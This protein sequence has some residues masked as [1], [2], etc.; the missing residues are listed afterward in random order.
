MKLS[1]IS[2]GVSFIRIK[3]GICLI[4]FFF[5]VGCNPEKVSYEPQMGT[6]PLPDNVDQLL[7]T[8]SVLT[9]LEGF[10]SD[11]QRVDSL[12]SYTDVLQNYKENIALLYAEKADSLAEVNNW[13]EA[14][15]FSKQ[16]IGMLKG[17][18]QSFGEKIEY[19]IVDAQIGLQLFEE[20]GNQPWRARTM[21][22][23]GSFFIRKKQTD[24]AD[25][26]FHRALD[27]VENANMS[28]QDS[29]FLRGEIFHAITNLYFATDTSKVL[30]SA[31]ETLELYEKADNQAAIARLKLSMG[32]HFIQL[33]EFGKANQLIQESIDYSISSRDFHSL[34]LG[35]R[36]RGLLK[37][38]QFKVERKGELLL[39]ALD[40][41]RKCEEYE[42]ENLYVTDNLI[43]YCF[44]GL[45][46]THPP[47]TEVYIDSALIYYKRAM[48]EARGE[49]VLPVMKI[50]G[51]NIAALCSYL[52]TYKN[53]DCGKI[54]GQSPAKLFNDNYIGIVDTITQTLQ[55]ADRR[56][57]NF[58]REEAKKEASQKRR[59]QL[60]IGTFLLLVCCLAF[61][62]W[63]D[64]EQQQKLR[65]EQSINERLQQ[66]DKLKD[67]FLANTSHE[68]RT[69][70][71]GIIGLS[72]SLIDRV[73]DVEQ[74]EDLSL[75]VA[76]G[77]RLSSLVDDLLDF[78]KLKNFDIEL[79]KKP[80]DLYSLAEVV[81][82]TSASLSGKDVELINSI[83]KDL[84]AVYADEGR[85]QQILY[86]LIGNALKF[87]QEGK[88]EIEASPDK[89]NPDKMMKIRI[90]DTGIG[91]PKEKHATIFEEFQQADGSTSRKFGGTGLGLTVTRQLVNLHKG[92]IGVESEVGKGATFWFTLPTSRETG[93]VM[94][95]L[96]GKTG[97][98]RLQS[99]REPTVLNP[100]PA[101]NNGNQIRILI[102]D[103][104]PINQQVLKNHLSDSRFDLG[105]AA[106]GEETLEI[107]EKSPDFDLVLLDVMMPKMS[108]Y[109][110]CEK[111]REKYL[112]SEL[113]IIMVTAKNQVEDLVQGLQLGANDYLAKPFSKQEFLARVNTQLDL[114]RFFN[115]AEKFVP[116][117]FIRSLGHERITDTQLGDQAERAVTVLFADIRD[118]T[119]LSESMTP[120]ENFRFVNS[121]HGRMGPVI[122]K[123]NGFVN[124][125]LGDGFMA[126]F[127]GNPGDAVRAT[128]EMNKVLQSY[129]QLRVSQ[130]RSSLR[131]GM[132]M[133]Y[134]SLIMGIIGD[135]TR[136]D[137]ATISDTVNTA[138]R[139]ESL[140]KHYGANI[141]LS[142][143]GI[144][145][146]A[147]SGDFH[148]RYLGPVQVRGKKELIRIYECI[149]GDLPEVKQKKLATLKDFES[150][151]AFYFAK[152]FASA[153]H[154]FD[155]MIK[156]NP[157]DKV[158]QHFLQKAG[159]LL[160]EGAPE[161][162]TGVE[163]MSKK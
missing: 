52:A 38:S 120:E 15:A 159:R 157:S 121:F 127:P 102:V 115:I 151:T 113:P 99:S 7:N 30:E 90:I 60:F 86:N 49:G 36:K 72:E 32:D 124:Q 26:Y 59:N 50:M 6:R 82:R 108:G 58:E 144:S 11:A 128:I 43:A 100:L 141:L 132:G 67:Q 92:E 9:H 98:N 114:H 150:G 57:R 126:I 76:S 40:V 103:D 53:R 34:V 85:I 143:E 95:I 61:L 116:I 152:D 112:P 110:A 142:A 71:N 69:P 129:N 35:Y 84:P 146:I 163:E 66:V 125:Y 136:M 56:I 12:L 118:Y 78:S 22:L 3:W 111:I 63:R 18:Q 4:A 119:S 5:L 147:V 41:L 83:P 48:E 88:I 156:E 31:R 96:S 101:N 42:K 55:G 154:V 13:T 20:V 145:Q 47:E 25:I 77:K 39:E 134:G 139:I 14:R 75:I 107:L 87:T 135:Q 17:R 73:T 148:F 130:N 97:I 45:A 105:F 155:K 137:A 65:Q 54:L 33:K 131:V 2:E 89:A 104:E 16:F 68:L 138:S 19:A 74:Q 161:G 70:L 149:D 122:K 1:G 79:A 21:V 109:E 37:I 24:S 28:K 64:K 44:Q 10:A 158:A 106:N 160:H 51:R 153:S 140:T 8:D 117:E 62:F 91:I 81:L 23:M 27:L 46:N 93:K 94:G 133:R 123:H 80:L 162:W 29:L